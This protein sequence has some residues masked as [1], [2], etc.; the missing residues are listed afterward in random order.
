MK[1]GRPKYTLQDRVRS[2]ERRFET[3]YQKLYAKNIRRAINEKKEK[4]RIDQMVRRYSKF[5]ASSIR[6]L[7]FLLSNLNSK[8]RSLVLL[9]ERERILLRSKLKGWS[10]WTRVDRLML[11]RRMKMLNR[12]SRD[13]YLLKL[14]VKNLRNRMRKG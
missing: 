6:K 3:L 4:K 8:K 11:Q 9:N 2:L 7:I 10:G 12:I 1:R 14:S 5:P 13:I